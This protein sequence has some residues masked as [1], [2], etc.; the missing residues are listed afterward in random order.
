[1]HSYPENAFTIA[2]ADNLDF[3]HSHARVYCGKQQSSWHGTTLQLVQ[4]QPSTL[5]YIS[6]EAQ[7]RDIAMHAEATS[8]SPMNSTCHPDSPAF[9]TLE[10]RYQACLS[11]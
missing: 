9:G 7:E 2:S 6:Q 3:I 10:T 1:M 11:K 4:P 8:D 5:V